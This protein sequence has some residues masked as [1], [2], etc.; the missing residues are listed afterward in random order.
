MLVE[1]TFARSRLVRIGSRGPTGREQEDAQQS[2]KELVHQ[3]DRPRVRNRSV[4]APVAQARVDE[5]SPSSPT[6]PKSLRSPSTPAQHSF[7]LGAT[8]STAAIKSSSP[9]QSSRAPRATA[10]SPPTTA[11]LA[12]CRT[13]TRSP[14]AIRS[15]SSARPRT[16]R[17]ATR[18]SSSASQPRS[19]GEPQ[20]ASRFGQPNATTGDQL[21][22][23]NVNWT[24]AGIGAGLAL[25]LVLLGVGA[26]LA[27]ATSVARRPLK[28]HAN[29][30]AHIVSGPT[31]RLRLLWATAGAPGRAGFHCWLLRL[32]PE[33]PSDDG[34]LVASA[35][36]FG[37]P[38][39]ASLRN[40]SRSS[41]PGSAA[42]RV[43]G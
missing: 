9:A 6:H 25:A 13:T 11:C 19:I 12:R 15:R 35:P 3:A 14:A 10:S 1:E 22:S 7:H 40:G 31:A 32:P 41:S 17:Q 38:L 42:R 43:A 30:A 5:G 23:W 16:E 18:S 34:R 26:A 24:D 36:S 21:A 4:R 27:A 33:Q 20:V 29:R 28:Q 39:R 8:S 37:L 2:E